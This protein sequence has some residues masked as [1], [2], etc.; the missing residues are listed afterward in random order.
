[1]PT[2]KKCQSRETPGRARRQAVPVPT[3][4]DKH[5]F[6]NY[7]HYQDRP[8]PNMRH[9]IASHAARHGPNGALAFRRSP[10]PTDR[11]AEQSLSAPSS[12]NSSMQA[13]SSPA[14]PKQPSKSFNSTSADAALRKDYE[15]ILSRFDDV[16]TCAGSSGASDPESKANI[17]HSEECSLLGDYLNLL[18]QH[19]LLF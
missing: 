4:P 9:T 2:S 12:K 5:L 17:V 13:R 10:E 18:A 6:V 7:S 8:D 11:V 16:C 1:M 19:E 15:T 14:T 3:M